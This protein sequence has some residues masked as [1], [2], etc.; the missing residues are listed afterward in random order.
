MKEYQNLEESS[1]IVFLNKINRKEKLIPQEVLQR[2][3]E[4]FIEAV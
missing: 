3:S 2:S 1:R 4:E